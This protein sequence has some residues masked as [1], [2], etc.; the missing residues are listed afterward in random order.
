MFTFYQFW[1]SCSYCPT[2]RVPVSVQASHC[3]PAMVCLG[4][5]GIGLHL[6][7]TCVCTISRMRDD[8]PVSI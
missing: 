6:C 3:T 7:M 5:H 4:V 2:K 8:R 1:T